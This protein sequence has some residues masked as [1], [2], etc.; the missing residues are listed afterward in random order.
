MTRVNYLQMIE[1]DSSAQYV[2]ID[3][4]QMRKLR[5]HFDASTFVSEA[6]S[7]LLKKKEKRKGKIDF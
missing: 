5:F 4:D 3:T 6:E 2:I 1:R 7:S